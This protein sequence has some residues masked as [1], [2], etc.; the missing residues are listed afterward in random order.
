MLTI[1]LKYDMWMGLVVV[2]TQ[3]FYNSSCLSMGNAVSLSIYFLLKWIIYTPII[4]TQGM[5][6]KNMNLHN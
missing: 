2:R 3:I 5:W 4:I 1:V 6:I